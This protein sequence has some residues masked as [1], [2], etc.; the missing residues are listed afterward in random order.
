MSIVQC[1]QISTYTLMVSPLA[2]IIHFAPILL[3]SNAALQV[4]RVLNF[5]HPRFQKPAGRCQT[6]HR[7]FKH[8]TFQKSPEAIPLVVS[9]SG[10]EFEAGYVRIHWPDAGT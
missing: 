9:A 5:L 2:Q 8:R 4:H 1:K 7:Q 3:S 6:P 10:R